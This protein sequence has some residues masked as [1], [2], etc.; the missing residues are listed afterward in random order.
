[1]SKKYNRIISLSIQLI[2][3]DIMQGH[4][5]WKVTDLARVCK[6]PRSQI[7]ELLGSTKPAI[8]NNALKT[9]LEEI[10]G[11]SAER[12][13][14]RESESHLIGVIQSRKIVMDAPELLSFYFRHRTR[15]DQIGQTI[16]YY[17]K[18]YLELVQ[19]QTKI[20]DKKLLLYIR[21][22]IHGISVAPYLSD[23]EVE[24]CLNIMFH[25]LAVKKDSLL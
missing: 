13:A 9:L 2:R 20:Q 19:K 4:L 15:E 21:T 16:R 3:M 6:Y 5:K 11:L 17:E 22:V 7:Y 1:M 14:L 8:L 24:D 25:S 23:A 18:K 10:Y 12:V